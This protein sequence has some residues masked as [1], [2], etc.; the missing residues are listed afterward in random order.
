V[1]ISGEKVM[2]ELQMKYLG[3]IIDSRW[4]FEPHFKQLVPR[5]TTAANALCGVLPNLGGAGLGV[6]RLYE[7][8]IRSRVLY[9]ATIWAED[10]SANRRSL[11]LVRGLHRMTV[12]RIIR[13][14]RTVSYASATVL[15]ASPP[16]ELQALALKKRYEGRTITLQ[17][18]SVVAPQPV[19]QEAANEEIWRRWRTQLDM[20]DTTRPH[21]AVRSVLPNWEAWKNRRGVPLT[22]RMTQMLTGHGVFGEFLLRIGREVT[23]ICHHYKEGEDTAQHTLGSC[24]AWEEPRRMQQ[25]EIGVNL[26]PEAIVEAALRD[27]REYS[28]VRVF[29]E[30]VILAK[31]WAE[32]DWIRTGDPAR[33]DRS[34]GSARRGAVAQPPPLRAT[35]LEI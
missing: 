21:R 9:G 16:F 17:Q 28:A 19:D 13:G 11:A 4:S 7:G 3:L 22:Y 6:R 30:R 5:V 32:R 24:T 31:E 26:A 27:R 35:S 14:Y 25:A 2:V 23:S 33:V 8:V 20:E 1:G 12:I 18:G 34:E 10:L 29:C 15:A